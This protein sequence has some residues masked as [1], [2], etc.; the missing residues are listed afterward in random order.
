MEI[1][2]VKQKTPALEF[3]TAVR[4]L[5]VDHYMHSPVTPT[6]EIIQLGYFIDL[7]QPCFFCMSLTFSSI[8]L[9][10]IQTLFSSSHAFHMSKLSNCFFHLINNTYTLGLYLE[11]L[12]R[13]S[14]VVTY[15]V[16]L[17]PQESYQS[18]DK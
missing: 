5:G 10:I 12:I 3:G 9:Y 16:L 1:L 4:N 17:L 18:F 8:N 2:S 6:P 13:N 7:T 15:I 11:L 14:I